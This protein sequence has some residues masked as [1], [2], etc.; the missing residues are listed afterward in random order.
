MIRPIELRDVPR[1]AEIHVFGWR[2]AY[3]G[4]VSDDFLFNHMIVSNRI[5]RFYEAVRNNTE[6]TYVFDDGIIKA[7]LTI[8]ICRDTDKPKS[9]ELWGI[10]VE[11]LMKRQGIGSIM[12]RFCEEKAMDRGFTE[13]C[14][15]VLKNNFGARPFYEKLGYL[16]DG[17]SKFIQFLNATEIRYCKKLLSV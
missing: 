17:N 4:I 6:E 1:A 14:L 10:Y 8:G 5:D 9:F 7:I 16:P 12:V 13:V 3:R 2:S 15:W 11:P